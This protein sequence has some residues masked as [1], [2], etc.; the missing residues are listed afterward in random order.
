MLC[1]GGPQKLVSGKP[2]CSEFNSRAVGLETVSLGYDDAA[3]GVRR[4]TQDELDRVVAEAG[5]SIAAVCGG[6]VEASIRLAELGQEFRVFESSSDSLRAALNRISLIDLALHCVLIHVGLVDDA[7]A[8]IE[9][10]TRQHMAAL[11]R[12]SQIAGALATAIGYEIRAD[13]IIHTS[14]EDPSPR[15]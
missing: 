6:D 12:D 8:P 7:G 5:A 3:L 14:E 15:H 4:T 13:F 10:L 1:R 2:D 11:V 9:T